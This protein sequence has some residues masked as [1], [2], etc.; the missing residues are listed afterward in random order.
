MTA[1]PE[2]T[3]TTTQWVCRSDMIAATSTSGAS[4]TQP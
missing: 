4:G 3:G 2:P 1:W